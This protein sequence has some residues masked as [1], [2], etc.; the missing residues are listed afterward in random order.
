MFREELSS[1]TLLQHFAFACAFEMQTHDRMK[2]L[3]LGDT[4]LVNIE[5]RGQLRDKFKVNPKFPLS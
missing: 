1:T 5:E 3:Y 2:L 4:K